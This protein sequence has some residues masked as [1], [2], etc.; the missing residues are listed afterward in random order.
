MES[1][2]LS[3]G[4]W[5]SGPAAA[6]KY[7]ILTVCVLS[8]LGS[9]LIISSWMF[10]KSIRSRSR[11]I[12]VCLSVADLG[13]AISNATGLLGSHHPDICEWQAGAA[14]FF[15]ASCLLWTIALAFYLFAAVVLQWQVIKQVKIMIA[16]YVICWGIPV[17]VT[18]LLIGL[19][20]LGGDPSE[21][22]SWQG[23][24]CLLKSNISHVDSA[25]FIFL[26]SEL[27][28]CLA[29]IVV[30]IL[31]FLTRRHIHREV[32]KSQN[33]LLSWNECLVDVVISVVEKIMMPGGWHHNLPLI[34][35]CEY[36]TLL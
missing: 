24:W 9:I 1:G 32:R 7:V 21:M 20:L 2:L 23:W 28:A 31:Y 10:F 5:D 29:Y 16:F 8:A 22:T 33:D 18:S 27:W 14:S 13:V 36:S 19:S 11:H 17:I 35:F 3:N 25:V 4:S 6:E 30:P 26:C 34:L 12:L 15:G